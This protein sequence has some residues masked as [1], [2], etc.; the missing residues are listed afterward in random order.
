MEFDSAKEGTVWRQQQKQAESNNNSILAKSCNQKDKENSVLANSCIR[1]DKEDLNSA[2]P[3]QTKQRT[4][5]QCESELPKKAS[6]F[7]LTAVI[8]PSMGYFRDRRSILLSVDK[9][10]EIDA[11]M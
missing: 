3:W 1:K 5:L 11:Y 4:R 8:E 9:R 2:R 7:D 6:Q 10:Q